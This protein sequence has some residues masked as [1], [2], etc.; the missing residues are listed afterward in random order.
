MGQTEMKCIFNIGK[1]ISIWAKLTQVSDVAHGPLVVL[2]HHFWCLF[3]SYTLGKKIEAILNYLQIKLSIFHL[4]ST[5][6]S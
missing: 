1:N 3:L 5:C 6:T 2:Y 4:T